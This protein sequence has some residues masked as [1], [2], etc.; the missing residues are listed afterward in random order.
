MLVFM[1]IE[2]YI[3]NYE[4]ESPDVSFWINEHALLSTNPLA[5]RGR[6]GFGGRRCC[7]IVPSNILAEKTESLLWGGLPICGVPYNPSNNNLTIDRFGLF[8][9]TF[10]V[11]RDLLE[12]SFG[13]S[14]DRVEIFGVDDAI[15]ARSHTPYYIVLRTSADCS[16]GLNATEEAS[17]EFI[18][19]WLLREDPRQSKI[20]TS[21]IESYLSGV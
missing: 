3:V 17:V 19:R 7:A 16:S 10:L 4:Y 6:G 15:Y 18:A 5:R 8:A 13:E 21:L 9:H 12:A 20:N 14:G 11:P 1:A 2:D